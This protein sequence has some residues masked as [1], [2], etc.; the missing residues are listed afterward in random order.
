LD[1]AQASG[2]GEGAKDSRNANYHSFTSRCPLIV[3]FGTANEDPLNLPSHE[4]RYGEIVP[5]GQDVTINK[6]IFEHLKVLL[7]I[8]LHFSHPELTD[9]IA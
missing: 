3:P 7:C 2:R 1:Y 5:T 9:Y 8:H 6:V 4:P